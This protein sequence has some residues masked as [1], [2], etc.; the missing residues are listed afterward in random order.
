MVIST[1]TLLDSFVA[2]DCG[3]GEASVIFHFHLFFVIFN[4]SL[5]IL[6]FVT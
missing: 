2:I 1:V 3:Q 6:I 4:K 5:I